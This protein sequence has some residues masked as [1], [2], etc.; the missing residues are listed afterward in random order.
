[1]T[2]LSGGRTT[3]THDANGQLTRLINPQGDR[4]S[5]TYDAAGQRTRTDRANRTWTVSS[6]DAAGRVVGIEQWW[7]NLALPAWSTLTV[8]QWSALTVDEWA[9]LPLEPLVVTE[10]LEYR[11]DAANRRV[12][13]TDLEQTRVTWSYDALGQLVEEQQRGL[14]VLD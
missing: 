12:G 7:R 13:R 2:D 6:Y 9:E 4:T 11:Y 10:Q 14:V 8:E 5:F 3:Y 1:M